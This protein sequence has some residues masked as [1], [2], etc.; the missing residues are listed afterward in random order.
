MRLSPIAVTLL[1]LAPLAGCGS[2]EAV[3]HAAP[4]RVQGMPA[5]AVERAEA[6]YARYVQQEAAALLR[7]TR[8]FAKAYA[9]GQDDRAKRLYPKARMH[10]ERIEPVAEAFGTLD[11]R[12]DLREADLAPGQDWTGWHRA[13]KDLWSA[14]SHGTDR[15]DIAR[16]LVADT[17][18]L[19]D[20]VAPGEYDALLM[21]GGAKELLDEVA[22]GK[23]TGEEEAFSHTDL[24]DF[25]ANVDGSRKAFEAL[26]PLLRAKDSGLVGRIDE[27]F[28]ALQDLLD[29]YRTPS[30][31]TSYERVSP[32]QRKALSDAVNALAEPV[33]TMTG[34]LTR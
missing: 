14:S 13:E 8:A 1:A 3:P 15:A 9:A 25:Q 31:F 28:D 18:E 34:V 29:R 16:R 7:E 33:A 17:T 32:V 19:R 20:K 6:R 30:G 24:V 21:A 22:S 12:L 23:V 26:A 2:R 27:R 10:W 11:P 5:A 4:A